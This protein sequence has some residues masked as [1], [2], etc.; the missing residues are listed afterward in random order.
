MS[1]F[2]GDG[3]DG[4]GSGSEDFLLERLG[5]FLEGGNFTGDCVKDLVNGGEGGDEAKHEG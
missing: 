3:L 5:P 2:V 1:F 4:P